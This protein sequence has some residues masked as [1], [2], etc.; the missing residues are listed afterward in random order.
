MRGHIKKRVDVRSRRR[1]RR[2]S[3]LKEYR[4]QYVRMDI[5]KGVYEH[6]ISGT[7]I[8][9]NCGVNLDSLT[10][11]RRYN[12][13]FRNKLIDFWGLFLDKFI[14]DYTKYHLHQTYSVLRS[15]L[16]FN[17]KY[18]SHGYR[19]WWGKVHPIKWAYKYFRGNLS[20]I[21]AYSGFLKLRGYKDYS[22]FLNLSNMFGFRLVNGFYKFIHLYKFLKTFENLYVKQY[23][24]AVLHTLTNFYI[25][26]GDRHSGA[27]VPYFNEINN[28]DVEECD[29]EHLL[30]NRPHMNVE[31]VLKYKLY[32]ISEPFL[33]YKKLLYS[34]YNWK[35]QLKYNL[36]SE[37]LTF[38]VNER[39]VFNNYKIRKNA[40]IVEHL[41]EPIVRVNI[42]RC[43]FET[44]YP[45]LFKQ[46]L[47]N[48]VFY[49]S[50]LNEATEDYLNK[51]L[52]P[53][54]LVPNKILEHKRKKYD[55]DIHNYIPLK[56][57]NGSYYPIDFDYN[58]ICDQ[59]ISVFYDTDQEMIGHFEYY[60]F[61]YLVVLN[62]ALK[63]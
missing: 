35:E 61:I 26:P 43:S 28:S 18:S 13:M 63:S 4:P 57:F 5:S 34:R 58:S 24:K 2:S 10:F 39:H 9:D 40:L 48:Y 21:S 51:L 52:E 3:E 36:F 1:L 8:I 17:L 46:S 15:D 53:F 14:Y 45:Y 12:I 32:G 16:D 19:Y 50:E 22:S 62:C 38:S 31:R 60:K 54:T 33:D 44:K 11:V 29:R 56:Y 47:H 55:M 23:T 30:E 20:F 7:V 59:D 6:P 42:R 27:L 25:H 49:N 41:K 37:P